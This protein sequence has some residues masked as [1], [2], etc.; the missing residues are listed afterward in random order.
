MI[1]AREQANKDFVHLGLCGHWCCTVLTALAALPCLNPNF[2]FDLCQVLAQRTPPVGHPWTAVGTRDRRG[3]S[4][5]WKKR[6]RRYHLHAKG[7]GCAST[8][9]RGAG[10]RPVGYWARY[11]VPTSSKENDCP[12]LVHSSPVT[13]I[14]T[15][16]RWSSV[17]PWAL[18][19]C[20]GWQLSRLPSPT[21]PH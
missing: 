15:E 8:Q 18:G 13:M 4:A 2:D 10:A 9:R 5:S 1:S 12:R 19:P 7:L 21:L 17:T 16:S 6:R 20:L 3:R 11:L 14:F